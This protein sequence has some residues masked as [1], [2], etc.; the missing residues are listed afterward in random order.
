MRMPS[1][2]GASNP[3]IGLLVVKCFEVRLMVNKIVYP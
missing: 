3:M 1:G 2:V